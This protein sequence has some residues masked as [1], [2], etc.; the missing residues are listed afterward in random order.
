ML[1]PILPPPSRDGLLVS[2]PGTR[3]WLRRQAQPHGRKAKVVPSARGL[4]LGASRADAICWLCGTERRSETDVQLPP[5]RW[6]VSD[7]LNA[8]NAHGAYWFSDDC[9]LF[10]LGQMFAPFAALQPEAAARPQHAPP[11]LRSA[12]APPPV[13]LNP[14]QPVEIGGR[15]QLRSEVTGDWCNVL[16]LL[17]RGALHV[18]DANAA[19]PPKERLSLRGAAVSNPLGARSGPSAGILLALGRA[20]THEMVADGSVEAADWVGDII[21]AIADAARSEAEE[22]HAAEAS[23]GGGSAKEEATTVA[24]GDVA[25]SADPD[26]H[27]DAPQWASAPAEAV[28]DRCARLVAVALAVDAGGGVAL[29]CRPSG[30]SAPESGDGDLVSPPAAKPYKIDLGRRMLRAVLGGGGRPPPSAAGAAAG[31]TP[32]GGEEVRGA[33]SGPDDVRGSDGSQGEPAAEAAVPAL[34]SELDFF[35][36]TRVGVLQRKEG[37]SGSRS[38]WFAL[39]G[40]E[41]LVYDKPPKC[42]DAAHSRLSARTRSATSVVRADEAERLLVFTPGDGRRITLRPHSISELRE[43]LAALTRHRYNLQPA[44]RADQAAAATDEGAS[45]GAAAAVAS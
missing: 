32:A 45:G 23:S 42:A 44:R 7:T 8:F 26:R 30:A 3:S 38:R 5:A 29:V 16:V 43:W 9:A 27:D 1:E 28:D 10:V 37:R 15:M 2:S 11:L 34:S 22:R 33:R 21:T 24:T 12:A 13:A 35:G 14:M 17:Q 4:P 6:V 41:L 25:A 20:A 19:A 18:F 31:S 36:A 40:H 39:V